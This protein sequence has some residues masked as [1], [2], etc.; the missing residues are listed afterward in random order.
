MGVYGL[1]NYHHIPNNLI[2]Q[3]QERRIIT[4]KIE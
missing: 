1:P 4:I 3:R 2:M